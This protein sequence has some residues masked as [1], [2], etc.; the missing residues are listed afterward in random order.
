MFSR[1]PLADD[2]ERFRGEV[3]A[4]VE[5]AF[6]EGFVAFSDAVDVAPGL[7]GVEGE[8]IGGGADDW[9]CVVRERWSLAS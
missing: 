4:V 5:F 1:V 3:A 2:R 7:G 9:A 6:D 8:F